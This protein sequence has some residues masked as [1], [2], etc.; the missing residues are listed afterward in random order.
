MRRKE[1]GKLCQN[2]HVVRIVRR[3]ALADA[4]ETAQEAA[5]VYV[6][7]AT[8]VLVIVIAH[9]LRAVQADVKNHVIIVLLDVQVAH[10]VEGVIQHVFLAQQ[11]AHPA[12]HATGA[13]EVV[14]AAK[15]VEVVLVAVE[16]VEDLVKQGAQDHAVHRA[17]QPAHQHA[18]TPVQE[19]MLR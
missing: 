11:I 19:R 4:L 12:H 7:H 5:A 17:K 9:V 1:G 3:T 18:I 6:L 16:S 2:V 14:Q 10:P 8:H 15:L 13:L